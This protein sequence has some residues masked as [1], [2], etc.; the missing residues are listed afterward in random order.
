VGRWL[1]DEIQPDGMVVRRHRAEVL[2]TKAEFPTKRL[3]QRE[4]DRRLSA[5]NSPTYRARPTAT[6]KDFAER[7]KAQVM[8]HHSLSTQSSEKSELK[9]WVASLGEVPTKD[10]SAEMLQSIIT[11]W[12]RPGKGKCS[13]KTT[14]NRVATFRLLWTSAKA[15]Q[16]VAHDP[17]QGL[18]MPSAKPEDEQPSFTTEDVKRIIN[19]ASPPYDV[20]FWTV[21]ETGIRRGEVCALDVGHVDLKNRI[22]TVRFSRWNSQ[23]TSTKSDK[24]RVFCLSPQL[25]ERL[26]FYVE[27][28]NAD[29]SLF[30]TQRGKR[31]HPDN[32]VK[33]QLKP[34]LKKLGLDGA[35]HAFRH[36]NATLLD[37]LNAPMKVRQE[38]L[39]HASA[40]TTMGY[41]HFISE[42]DRKI[43]AELGGL[44]A[45][46]CSS[47]GKTRTA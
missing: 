21:A 40:E 3:A 7:W 6:F 5:V 27:S 35:L 19:A 47:P 17:F 10:I 22:I 11:Y 16:Y 20:V 18:A 33:R 46:V 25:I 32:F 30:L 14:R 1:D 43:A 42:D 39:G 45:Q 15:W 2:G 41:T 8:I 36:G 26:R 31:L 38:R 23:I 9:A 24:P 44:F 34:I 4:L 37:S 28:R 12:S 13:G 29:E